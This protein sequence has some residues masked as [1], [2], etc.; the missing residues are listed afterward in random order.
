MT[1]PKQ[2]EMQQSSPRTVQN[3]NFGLRW[4]VPQFYTLYV[5]SKL[6]GIMSTFLLTLDLIL[7]E[8]MFDILVAEIYKLLYPSRI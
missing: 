1:M 8:L 2:Y 7:A 3:W 6:E 4:I 5:D